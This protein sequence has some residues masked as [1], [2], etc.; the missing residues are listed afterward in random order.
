MTE[1]EAMFLEFV[2]N[3]FTESMKDIIHV[4]VT[5]AP[6]D[7]FKDEDSRKEFQRRF[8]FLIQE[9]DDLKN[10]FTFVNLINPIEMENN[11]E[12]TNYMRERWRTHRNKLL[13]VIVSSD[14]VCFVNDF[15]ATNAL[16]DWVRLNVKATTDWLRFDIS[17]LVL[18]F[19]CLLCL[20]MVFSL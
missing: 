9:E 1:H 17:K 2:K 19:L 5:H 20:T 11:S 3:V 4:I 13:E 14:K 6:N 10:R 16:Q 7:Y 8:S 12:L 15:K 18:C